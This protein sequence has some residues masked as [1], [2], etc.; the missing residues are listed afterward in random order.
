[1]APVRLAHITASPKLTS[2]SAGLSGG[3]LPAATFHERS[4]SL[5]VTAAAPSPATSEKTV[6]TLELSDAMGRRSPRRFVWRAP[7]RKARQT[8]DESTRARTARARSSGRRELTSQ[9]GAG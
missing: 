2:G 4:S 8:A 5:R 9:Y 3:F 1:M 6:H 7:V